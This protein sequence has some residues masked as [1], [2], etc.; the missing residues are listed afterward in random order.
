MYF[1]VRDTYIIGGKKYRPCIC[2]HTES[3]LLKNTI[4]N[5]V[6]K[7]KAVIYEE[8]RFFC[9]GKLVKTKAEQE[10]EDKAKKKAEREE[11]KAKKETEEIALEENALE[12]NV[13]ET[14]GF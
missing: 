5:L 11:K 13:K 3:A 12:E 7:D 9:N 14:E 10:A 2:Y 6:K 8:K 1:S 4:E